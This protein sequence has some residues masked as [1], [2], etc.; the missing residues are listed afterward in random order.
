[1]L[2][3]TSDISYEAA[4]VCGCLLANNGFLSHVK[5]KN[6]IESIES[7]IKVIKETKEKKVLTRS[8]WSISKSRLKKNVYV[9]KNEEIVETVIS[10]LKVQDTSS[11]VVL[12]ALQVIKS[13]FA[14][15]PD[16]MG[17]SARNWYPYVFGYMFHD[18]VKVRSL[19]LAIID[20]GKNVLE[21]T[22]SSDDKSDILK[23]IIPDLKTQHCKQMNR[24]VVEES[25]DMLR[26]WRIIVQV[27][28]KELHPGTSLINVLLEVVEKAFK[29]SKPEVRVSAFNC[30]EE[31][32]DNFSLDKSVLTHS[33]RLK[34]LLAPLKAN[35]A[36]TEEVAH[37]KLLT[38]WHLVCKLGK[39]AAVNFDLVVLP[40]LRFCFGYGS[41]TG[42]TVVGLAERNLI[43]SG[44]SASPGRKFSNLHVPCAEILAQILSKG[45]DIAG[46]QGYNFTIPV[47]EEPVVTTTTMFIRYHQLLLNCTCDAVQS[48][49]SQEH[50]PYLLG[51]FLF[52]S[53]LAHL[54][55]IITLD[56]NK[57]DCVEPVKALFNII[58]S[59]EGQCDRG[60]PQ[61][62]FVL[63][64]LEMVIVGNLALP[65]NVY[66][67]PAY[68]ISKKMTA[69]DFMH[70]TLS[71]H[72]IR[73][74]CR[75]SLFEFAP[76]GEG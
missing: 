29:S 16:E 61:S 49:N 75:P 50:K 26:Q 7:L 67:N 3:E 51:V 37:A 72:L 33:K 17:Q 41:S 63:K 25:I 68:C 56:T 8:L 34:L 19:A 73:Q 66:N 12:E 22:T 43:M 9:K 14:V 46:L 53:V 60:D 31:L 1:M 4:G 64:F 21:K 30:W 59:L 70:G 69:R 76:M 42:G 62:W 24:L 2:N 39:K 38:W 71:N 20:I 40:L 32:I 28:G 13:L 11:V 6:E 36:K 18:A 44:A 45:V 10:I 35:N 65:K 74:L 15:V 23:I 54:R 58:S 55:V 48:L 27:L 57:K 5:Y 47:L 52:Q